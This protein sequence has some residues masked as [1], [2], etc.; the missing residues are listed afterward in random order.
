M[1]NIEIE[2]LLR[3]LVETQQRIAITMEKQNW[4]FGTI[5]KTLK[6]INERKK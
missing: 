3:E 5:A 1:G 2:K 6:E 4:N